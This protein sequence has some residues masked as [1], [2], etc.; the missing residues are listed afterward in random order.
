MKAVAKLR[1]CPTSPRKM[2]LIIDAIRGR[3][4][5]DAFGILKYI[6]KGEAERV[7]KLL[8]SAVSNWENKNDGYRA[9]DS[10]LYIAEAKVDSGRQLKRLRPAPFGRAH[11]IRKRSNHVTLVIDSK[12]EIALAEDEVEVL[13]EEVVEET[14][15]T[16]KKA[17]K[18][19]AAAASKK[20]KKDKKIDETDS[21]S[22]EEE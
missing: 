14:K 15:A 20:K 19:T 4:V 11:R 5:Y 10:E 12:V 16:T 21:D 8:R 7:E 17:A 1:N 18:A 2:R 9:E 22:S 3:N 6:R 13:E